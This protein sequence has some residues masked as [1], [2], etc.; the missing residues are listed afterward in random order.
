[1]QLPRSSRRFLIS[2]EIS[3]FALRMHSAHEANSYFLQHFWVLL[4]WLQTFITWKVQYSTTLS[5]KLHIYYKY[6][7]YIQVN[8]SIE[9]PKVKVKT[10]IKSQKHKNTAVCCASRQFLSHV[11]STFKIIVSSLAKGDK[12]LRFY[13]FTFSKKDKKTTENKHY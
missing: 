6:S 8:H 13:N 2:H 7:C 9:T 11:S 1:M 12:A 4:L 5:K 3:H 10:E